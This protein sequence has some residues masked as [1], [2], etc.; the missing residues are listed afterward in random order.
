MTKILVIEDETTL[1]ENIVQWLSFEGYE[2]LAA[3]DGKDGLKQAF[4]HKPDLIVCDIHM[5]GLSGYEVL[6]KIQTNSSTR[7]TPFIFLTA[8]TTSDDIRMGMALGADDYI[9]KPFKRVDLHKAIQARLDKRAALDT[10]HEKKLAEV[11]EMVTHERKQRLLQA[12]LV[13]MFSHDFRTPLTSILTSN[14]LL[15]DFFDKMDHSRRVKQMDRINTNTQRLIQLLDDLLL[16]AQMETGKFVFQPEPLDV[17]TFLTEIVQEFQAIQRENHQIHLET[18]FSE[19]IMGDPR[20][21]RQIFTNL[22]SNAIKYSPPP[23]EIQI[24]LKEENEQCVIIVAD[25]GIGIPEVDLPRLFSDFERGSNVGDLS[26]TGLGLAIVKQALEEHGGTIEVESEVGVGTK[27]TVYLP[28]T[29]VSP[30][31]DAA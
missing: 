14:N 28:L 15:R 11:K 26:G 5:P 13:A 27:F 25:E 31:K 3:V 2:V 30:T 10:V 22:I 12:K 4:L 16:V 9:T 24:V 19:T 17:A 20:L 8:R 1:R 23:S 6:E 21:L 29:A 7:L 18:H